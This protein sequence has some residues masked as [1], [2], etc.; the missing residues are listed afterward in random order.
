MQDYNGVYLDY[1]IRNP[2][3]ILLFIIHERLNVDVDARQRS[4]EGNTRCK[5][6]ITLR[7]INKCHCEALP[8]EKEKKKKKKSSG[9]FPEL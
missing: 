7:V 1:F 3:E 8:W 5:E 4:P 9:V 2:A 6:I